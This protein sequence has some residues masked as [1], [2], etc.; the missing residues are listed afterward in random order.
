VRRSQR[1]NPGSG[2][3]TCCWG[4][5]LMTSNRFGRLLMTSLPTCILL[6]GQLGYETALLRAVGGFDAAGTSLTGFG[7]ISTWT[8]RP[9]IAGVV[10]GF[11]GRVSIG[12]A[13]AP[14]EEAR[15]MPAGLWQACALEPPTE[16]GGKQE[17]A[18]KRSRCQTCSPP[19]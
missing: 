14:R 4:S 19:R 2:R 5:R 8:F 11:R 1:V 16:V 7:M 3:G 10:A 12:F 17:P 6:R 9:G 15:L 13:N 18:R